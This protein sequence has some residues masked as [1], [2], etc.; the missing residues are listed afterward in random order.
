MIGQTFFPTLTFDRI[1]DISKNVP[2]A[3]INE[4]KDIS[5]LDIRPKIGTIKVLSQNNTEIQIDFQTG[6][7]LQVAHRRT[8]IIESIHEGSFFHKTAPFAIFLPAALILLILLITGIY[9]F[10]CAFPARIRKN[11]PK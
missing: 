5:R 4:W 3:K 8:G 6:D 9:L 7:I 11:N 1:L 2:N 10:I